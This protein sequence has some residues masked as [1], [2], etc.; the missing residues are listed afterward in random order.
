MSKELA[1]G[2]TGI[3]DGVRV[4]CKESAPTYENWLVGECS[5]YCGNGMD[6]HCV[7]S[8]RRTPCGHPCEDRADRTDVYFKRIEP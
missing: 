8:R 5:W 2:E 4:E 1:I 3:I 6:E 7:F